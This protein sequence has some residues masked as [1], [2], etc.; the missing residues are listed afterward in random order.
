MKKR[1]FIFLLWALVSCKKDNAR[2]LSEQ[3]QKVWQAGVV[4]EGA[5][6]VF[7]KGAASNAKP[8]YSQYRLDLSSP[9]LVKLTDFDANTFAGTWELSADQKMLILKGLSPQPSGTNGLIEF[10]IGSASDKTL[11]ITRLTAS[12]KTGGTI[13]TYDLTN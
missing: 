9:T 7:T 11:T 4:K 2:P 10:S 12:V 1:Y 5:I 13:N 3:I 6:T 8:G